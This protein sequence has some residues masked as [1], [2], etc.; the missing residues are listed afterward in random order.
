[1]D[2]EKEEDSLKNKF[3]EQLGSG[4]NTNKHSNGN[5]KWVVFQ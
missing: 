3:K 1:M 2:G 5:K 4:R